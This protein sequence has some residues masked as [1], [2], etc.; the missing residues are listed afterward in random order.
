MAHRDGLQGRVD[1]IGKGTFKTCYDVIEKHYNKYDDSI[2]R[3][4]IMNY[5]LSK[6]KEYKDSSI[7]TKANASIAIFRDGLEKEALKLC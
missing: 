1:S 4:T 7:T 6:G 5:R 2:I 3:E